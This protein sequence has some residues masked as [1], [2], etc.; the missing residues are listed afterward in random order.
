MASRMLSDMLCRG[1]VHN[2]HMAR[3]GSTATAVRT[4]RPA[5]VTSL[6]RPITQIARTQTAANDA[7]V[8]SSVMS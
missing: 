8:Y 7:F 3:G 2:R 5:N 1:A 4:I 6:A